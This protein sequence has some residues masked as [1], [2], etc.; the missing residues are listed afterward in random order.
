MIDC[1]ASL[2]SIKADADRLP[3]F[4]AMTENN[5]TL[6]ADLGQQAAEGQSAR[7]FVGVRIAPD[8]AREL[9][10][11]TAGLKQFRVRAIAEADIHLTLVPPWDEAAVP[12][13]IDRLCRVATGFKS[14]PLALQH[15]GYG[16]HAKRP[17]L[18]WADCT[19]SRELTDLH[20]ALLEAYGQIDERPFRPHVTLARIRGN[21]AALARSYPIDQTLSLTQQVDSIELFQS[22]PPG[23]IGY[24]ILATARLGATSQ[25]QASEAHDQ[26]ADGPPL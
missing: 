9:T 2:T 4:A 5:N 15:V 8:I 23:Q 24:K 17:R 19:E 16:P 6:S 13:A 10:Q 3:D 26:G 1:S 25:L 21:G 7:V 20:T 18:V 22:P 11:L 14:F 12:G